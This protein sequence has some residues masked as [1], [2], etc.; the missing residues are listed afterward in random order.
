MSGTH[1]SN[2][3]TTCVSCDFEPFLRNNYFTGKMMSA[4]EFT[5]ETHYHQEKMRLHQARLHGWGVVCGLDVLQHPNVDCRTRY[6][7]IEPGS[8]VDCCGRDILVPEEEMLDLLCYDAVAALSREN[9]ARVHALSICVR[10]VECATETV[11]VLYDDCGCD[12]QGCAPNRILES[13]AFDVSVDPPLSEL[14][15][16]KVADIAGALFV[17]SPEPQLATSSPRFGVAPLVGRELYAL[18]AGKP[19]QLVGWNVA[20]RH[21]DITELNAATYSVAAHNGFVLVATAPTTG[22]AVSIR[23]FAPGNPASLAAVDVPGTT[24]TDVVALASSTDATRAAIVYVRGSGALHVLPDDATNGI[25]TTVTSLGSVG[26]GLTSF[27]VKTDGATAYAVDEAAAKVLVVTLAAASTSTTLTSLPNAAHPTALQYFLNGT[28]EMLAVVSRTDRLLYVIDLAANTLR[29]TVTL[30]HS[31]E[32]VAAGA[33]GLL[34]VVEEDGGIQY[35]QCIDVA[36]L[37]SNQSVIVS[38]ARAIGGAG[39]R[40][41]ALEQNG[42][43]G[44][45][46]APDRLDIACEEILYRQSCGG[47]DTP[48]CMTLATIN[49]YQAGASVLDAD[50]AVSLADD[51]TAR[52]ARIDNR[53]GRRVLASTQTLQAWIE[54]LQIKG[55]PGPAGANGT[56][57][58]PGQRGDDGDDGIGLY[59][60]LP[61]ILDIGWRFEENRD[62]F[63]QFLNDYMVLPPATPDELIKRI[64][65][66]VRQG[67]PP[68]LTIYF[69]RVMKG[70][71]RRTLTVT[72]D[73][74]M[75][76][77]DARGQFTSAGAYLPIEIRPYGD[78]VEIPGPVPTPH[79]GETAAFAVSFVPRPEFWATID[80]N[81]QTH[82]SWSYV[83]LYLLTYL[84]TRAGVDPPRV[85]VKLQGEFVYAPDNSGNYTELGVL[86]GDNIGGRVGEAPPPGRLLPLLGG[87]NPSGNLTQG[88]QFQSWFFVTMGDRRTDDSMENVAKASLFRNVAT[89]M[90]GDVQLPPMANF[91]SAQELAAIPGVT[92]ALARKIVKE[93][94]KQLFAGPEDLRKRVGLNERDFAKIKDKLAML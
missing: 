51:L 90:L 1:K 44:I 13:F 31:P 57:G 47:C 2:D 93:R 65:D 30:D 67:D 78:V 53:E 27:V 25:G 37:A 34:Y 89:S 80:A 7:R 66:R 15:R 61:K 50:P 91:S 81:G 48:N 19:N 63:K 10:F 32:Y 21:A 3:E 68:P 60:D 77:A 26:S 54:C 29:A 52:R 23:S 74:P 8:A 46:A 85:C 58:D 84:T 16:L 12:D 38:A 45:A 17:R 28:A 92:E 6:V 62:F 69:N 94:D 14:T 22:T 55:I 43:A 20:T 79:T 88:G 36:P 72:I 82:A 76:Q 75:P 71:T 87:K 4:A 40:I 49:R 42:V 11:P 56:N 73:S 9:P 24:S 18:D 86:D 70:I 5:A 59:P 39:L 83:L 41:V 64:R 33:P 35:L